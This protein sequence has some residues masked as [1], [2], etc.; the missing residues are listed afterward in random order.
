[1]VSGAGGAIDI[2]EGSAEFDFCVFDSNRA[3]Y[4]G[5][6]KLYAGA[7]ANLVNCTFTRNIG[8]RSSGFTGS[9][10]TNHGGTFGI[11]RSILALN[12]NGIVVS[13]ASEAMIA[14]QCNDVFGNEDGNYL[15]CLAGYDGLYSNFSLDPEFCDVS[16]GILRLNNSSACWPENSPCGYLV[17]AVGSGCELHCIDSDGDGFGDP[18][19]PDNECSL[20]NCPSVFNPDQS[21]F[22]YDGFGDSCDICTDTDGDGLGNPGFA[23][24]SCPIDNCPSVLNIDQYDGDGDGIGDAC[25]NCFGIVNPDQADVDADSIG[26]L[27][28]DCVDSD[29]DG[30]ANP[31]YQ[32]PSCPIDN[33]PFSF[34]I[35]QSDLDGDGI[36][37]VC[38]IVCGD[39]NGN[40]LLTVSDVVYI[41][42]FIFAGG[43]PPF[44]YWG[45]DANCSGSINISD[46]VYIVSYIFSGGPAPCENCP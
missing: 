23:A 11:V 41:I 5:A 2:V 24:S 46:A 29:D 40:G 32:S 45:G 27:C 6:V 31:G 3:S 19:V 8:I 18:G 4:A 7:S 25:D 42:N 28:D 10:L 14:F 38:D 33:C 35:D 15:G 26:D 9:V 43:P 12:G 22:D 30:F 20:D 13:S 36:G 1:M 37:D 39:A 34:N 21:D 16:Q 17:G 44:P